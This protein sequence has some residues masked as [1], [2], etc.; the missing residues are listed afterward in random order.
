[1][2]EKDEENTRCPECLC[3]F[4]SYFYIGDTLAFECLSCSHVHIERRRN[5]IEE[6]KLSSEEMEVII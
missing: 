5:K 1:M 6:N 2:R 4:T 3:H